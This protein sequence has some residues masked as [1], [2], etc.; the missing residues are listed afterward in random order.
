MVR[1]VPISRRGFCSSLLA[2][3]FSMA[4][5]ARAAGSFAVTDMLGR[6]VDVPAPPQRIVLLE[7]RDI[8]TMGLLHPDPATLLAGWA[9]VDRIDSN[10]LCNSLTNGRDIPVVGLQTPDTLSLEGLVALRP[11]L[12]VA[13]SYMAPHGSDDLMVKRLGSFGIPVVFSDMSSNSTAQAVADVMADCRN[14]LRMWGEILG[15]TDR[16]A[17]YVALVDAKLSVTAE[18]LSDVDPAITYLEVQS[19]MDSCC[20]A[21][22][23]KIWGELLTLAG[24]RP[25]PGVTAPWFQQL[26]LEY[27]IATPQ[28]AY[29]ATGGSW[30]AGGRPAIGPGLDQGEGRL[31]LERMIS[32]TG[33]A[34][35]PSVKAGAVHGIWTGL[36]TMPP[37]NILFVEQVAKWL[38]PDRC[39][40]LDPKAT[41]ADINRF[42]ARPLDGPLW[43]SLKD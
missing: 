2:A 15:T 7:A 41:L 31:G 12:V 40:D 20:W 18:R 37:L 39:A 43:L 22:G 33:F 14:H 34:D 28:D 30:T 17:A 25:L 19:S 1:P 5:P 4:L 9:A 11:D 26:S 32:R 23:Q 10:T 16:A 38:H 35:L 36:I 3:S 21:A 29:I 6:Q 24:G 27:L 42:L 13:S 8:L